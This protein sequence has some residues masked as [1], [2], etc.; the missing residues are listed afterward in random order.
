MVCAGTLPP[1]GKGV[2]DHATSQMCYP[3]EFHR[4]RS[5]STSVIGDAPKI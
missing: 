5:N 2:A 3:T 1:C 4:S